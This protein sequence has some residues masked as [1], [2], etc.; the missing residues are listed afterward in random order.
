ME[1]LLSWMYANL[2]TYDRAVALAQLA[3][4]SLSMRDAQCSDP[5]HFIELVWCRAGLL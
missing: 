4:G 5:Q 3:D 2:K 1:T